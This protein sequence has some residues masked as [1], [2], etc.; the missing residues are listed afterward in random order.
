MHTEVM[1][2]AY[3]CQLRMDLASYLKRTQP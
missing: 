1:S 2:C 3:E